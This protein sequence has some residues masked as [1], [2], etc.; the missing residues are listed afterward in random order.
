MK[1]SYLLITV[2]IILTIA[3]L[4]YLSR[5]NITNNDVA[6]A[7]TSTSTKSNSSS[8]S[9][10]MSNA[11]KNNEYTSAP[12]TLSAAELANKT[13][14]IHTSKGDITI[15]LRG[16]KAPTTVSNFIFLSNNGFYDTLTFHRR[17]EGFVIQGGDPLGTGTGGPGYTV[18]AEITDLSHKTGAVAMARLGDSVNPSR[19]SSGS[20][21]Y[22]TLGDASFLDNQYTVFGYVTA[23]M[24]V[25]DQIKVGDEILHIEIK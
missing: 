19:A 14:I 10:N 7:S 11:S 17:E 18:P 25:V 5:N 9:T 20:Q 8:S 22:I 24:D 13:A 15:Q 4:V 6:S 21:F 16:D 12:A 2:I 23:G 1:R 3:A